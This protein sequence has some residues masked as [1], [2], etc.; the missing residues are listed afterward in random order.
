MLFSARTCPRGFP[1]RRYRS[2]ASS[3]FTSRPAIRV[4][5][6]IVSVVASWTGSR[7]GALRRAIRMTNESFAGHPGVTTRAVAFWRA[8][9]EVVPRAG[10]EKILGTDRR[11]AAV[12]SHPR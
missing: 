8:Q 7:T 4:R 11:S 5:P 2:S 1:V 12:Q 10:M 6:D 9:P 3:E